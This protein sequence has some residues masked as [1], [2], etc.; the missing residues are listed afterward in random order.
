[1]RVANAAADATENTHSTLWQ[2]GTICE[3]ICKCHTYIFIFW[4]LFI[5]NNHINIKT[6]AIFKARHSLYFLK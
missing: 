5:A 2:R 6:N 3:T 4:Y 1:M